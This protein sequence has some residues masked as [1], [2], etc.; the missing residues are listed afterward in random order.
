MKSSDDHI[1]V[2]NARTEKKCLFFDFYSRN[3]Y[4]SAELI[5]VIISGNAST[6]E[7][8]QMGVTKTKT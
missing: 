8:I 5:T 3:L 4:I 1:I 6:I 7:F 2:E